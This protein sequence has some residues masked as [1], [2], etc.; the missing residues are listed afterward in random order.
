MN[1]NRTQ[2]PNILFIMVDQLTAALTGAYDHPVVKTPNLD[3]LVAESVRFDTAYSNCPVC[4]PARGALMTGRY[5]SNCKVYDNA[6]AWPEDQ[7]TI[8]HYLTLAGYDTVLSG[9]MHF[10]SADQLHGFRRRMVSNI[11]PADFKWTPARQDPFNMA[12]GRNCAQ[13][14]DRRINM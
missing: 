10:V 6:A 14:A 3:R 9:K 12:E 2:Q 4:G 11:Y 7:I 13:P 1:D 5:V 8:P